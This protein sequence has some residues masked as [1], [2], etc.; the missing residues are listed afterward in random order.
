MPYCANQA[1]IH[2]KVFNV[3][4]LTDIN[5]FLYYTYSYL[6]DFTQL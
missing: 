6:M 1:S 5:N 4:I 3:L 2:D